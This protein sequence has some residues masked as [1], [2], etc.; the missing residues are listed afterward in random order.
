M[1]TYVRWYHLD[2]DRWNYD[3]LDADG[4]AV[5][6]VE[7]RGADGAILAAASLA[8]VLAARDAGDTRALGRYERR[9]G[10]VPEAPLPQPG[11]DVE[12]AME[13]ISAE[14]FEK[15]WQVARRDLV[16]RLP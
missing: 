3:E 10:I 7:M 2:E 14:E 12:P 9:Y 11:R 13:E 1:L 16:G 8:E 4:W 5:R 15:L 6:H